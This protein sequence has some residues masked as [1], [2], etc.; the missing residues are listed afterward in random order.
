VGALPALDGDAH[1]RGDERSEERDD[2][3]DDALETADVPA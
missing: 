3:E 2:A 1:E